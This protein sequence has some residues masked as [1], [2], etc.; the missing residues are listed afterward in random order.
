[1]N[2]SREGEGEMTWSDGSSYK[3][4]WRKGQPNGL[5][6][7]STTQVRSTSRERSRRRDCMRIMY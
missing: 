4:D 1:M 2:D 7:A 3:G 5:G 6:I